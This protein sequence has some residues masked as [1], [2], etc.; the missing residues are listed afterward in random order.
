MIRALAEAAGGPAAFVDDLLPNLDSVAE[1]APQ[2]KRYQ[3]VADPALRSLAPAAP[4]RH[5]RIDSWPELAQAIEA[6]LFAAT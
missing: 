5:R 3:L 6:D 4:D 1:A 2:V